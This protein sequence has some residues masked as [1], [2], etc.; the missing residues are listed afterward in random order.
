MT[1]STVI[2]SC[3]T[4]PQDTPYLPPSRSDAILRHLSPHSHRRGREAATGGCCCCCCCRYSHFGSN[5]H[6][7][8]DVPGNAQPPPLPPPPPHPAHSAQQQPHHPFPDTPG[9]PPPFPTRP[10]RS[11]AAARTTH[12]TR[13]RQAHRSL[14]LPA[15]GLTRGQRG[16]GKVGLPG[17][18]SSYGI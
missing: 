3:V 9:A 7:A 17:D 13:R 12:P 14:R 4:L 16:G 2:L 8:A 18:V 11:L 10:A 1:C 6:P 15:E 5:S